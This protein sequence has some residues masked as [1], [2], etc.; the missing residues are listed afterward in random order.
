ML[1]T[2]VLSLPLQLLIVEIP[3]PLQISTKRPADASLDTSCYCSSSI[4]VQTS[5]LLPSRRRHT[6]KLSSAS[7][8]SPSIDSPQHVTSVRFLDTL[9]LA[10]VTHGLYFYL[11]SNF[12]NL[13]A[14][15]SPT[16]SFL[17]EIYLTCVSDFIVRC[18]YGRRVWI[19]TG[20]NKLL[21][22][23]IAITST[24]T[25]VTGFAFASRAFSV[26]TFENFSKISYFLY[27]AL[28]SGVVADLLIA[29]SLCLYL[30]KSRTGF[31]KTD[32]IVNA[33]IMYAINT[34]LLTTICSA[35]CFITYTIWPKEFTFIGIYFSLSKLYLNS[36]LATLNNR[37]ALAEKI[38]GVS[39]FSL[40]NMNSPSK[41]SASRHGPPLVV[42]I[43]R[44]VV[45]SF[46]F[47]D[48][49]KHGKSTSDI[50]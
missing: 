19:V 47:G 11:V 1:M 37:E 26:K 5:M 32:S 8:I 28:G 39:N 36:L 46:E 12:G 29:S 31:R 4:H 34:S 14:L 45:N 49:R 21:A 48:A 42:S 17:V 44:E 9:H 2:L 23:C 20:Q 41:A 15:V 13:V 50:P 40:S 30:S 6:L 35:A 22:A 18:I 24:L 10:F 33:L 27:I 43:D 38:S 7:R 16:W 3:D 25:C